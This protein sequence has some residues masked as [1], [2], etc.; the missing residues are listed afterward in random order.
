[1]KNVSYEVPIQAKTKNKWFAEH[2][3]TVGAHKQTKMRDIAVFTNSAC[4]G[5]EE[6]F[7]NYIL[8][9]TKIW[10]KEGIISKP[11]KVVKRD[12]TAVCSSIKA[13]VLHVD[14]Q[15]IIQI[16]RNQDVKMI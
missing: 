9:V 8:T 16:I 13:D 3:K 6:I 4:I 10:E 12:F 11:D 5:F 2:I 1:M 7:R 15:S 14:Y